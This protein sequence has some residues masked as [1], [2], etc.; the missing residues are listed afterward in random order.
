M[1]EAT[2]PEILKSERGGYEAPLR[3]TK[4]AGYESDIPRFAYMTHGYGL[5]REPSG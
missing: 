2:S 5:C 1:N 3:S 4:S